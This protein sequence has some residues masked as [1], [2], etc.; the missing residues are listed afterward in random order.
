[1]GSK[2]GRKKKIETWKVIPKSR[3]EQ[4]TTRIQLTSFSLDRYY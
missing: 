2:D 1:M 4:F 3:T